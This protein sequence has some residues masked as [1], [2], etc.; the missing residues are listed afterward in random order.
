M[1]GL[2][3]RK[4]SKAE[5][6]QLHKATCPGCV[7]CLQTQ[8]AEA[9]RERDIHKKTVRHVRA[10]LTEA[11][12]ENK[13]LRRR[14]SGK[15]R[16]SLQLGVVLS[17]AGA[18]DAQALIDGYLERAKA[19]DREKALELDLAKMAT[20]ATTLGQQ[21][22]SRTPLTDEERLVYNLIGRGWR[23]GWRSTPPAILDTLIEK[24]WIDQTHSVV[25]GCW[26]YQRR[27]SLDA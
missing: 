16:I 6:E 13:W 14:M 27:H 19:E 2:P 9:R 25:G 11:R 20:A 12:A 24:G 21:D 8:L 7:N 1:G 22:A 17:K 3:E 18:P 5:L 10:E 26:V 4:W 15:P 23:R